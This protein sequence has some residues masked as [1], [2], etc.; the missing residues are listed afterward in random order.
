M[1]L[2]T[3]DIKQ[4]GLVS[5]AGEGIQAGSGLTQARSKGFCVDYS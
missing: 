2:R 4:W 1:D 3:E 5:S